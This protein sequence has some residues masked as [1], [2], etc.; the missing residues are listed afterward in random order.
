MGIESELKP[1]VDPN[2]K[3]LIQK[4]LAYNAKDRPNLRE[5]QSHKAFEEDSNLH[6]IY[7][8]GEHALKNFK[9]NLEANKYL[10]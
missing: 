1:K 7:M 4:I 9:I 8:M 5:I 10:L 3:D 6:K 2:L